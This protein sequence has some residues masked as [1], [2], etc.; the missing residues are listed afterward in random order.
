[1]IS[2]FCTSISNGL[3]SSTNDCS[4]LDKIVSA[5]WCYTKED[6]EWV[7]SVNSQSSRKILVDMSPFQVGAD[8]QEKTSPEKR[9]SNK[10]K[11]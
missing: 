10:K 5:S 1:M 8:C 2:R 4:G 11:Q 6:T 7:G 3:T 9:T